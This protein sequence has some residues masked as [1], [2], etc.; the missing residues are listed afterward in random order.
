[1]PSAKPVV[2][3]DQ[4]RHLSLV[5]RESWPITAGVV[6][7]ACLLVGVGADPFKGLDSRWGDTLLRLRF[8]LGL[9]PR[10]DPNIFLIGLETN[11]LVGTGTIEGEYRIYA[12]I[13]DIL[14]DL[15]VSAVGMDLIMMRGSERDSRGVREAI[16]NN[17]H[18][19]LAE[20]QLPRTVA[21]SFPF[22]EREFPSG[23]I[24]I[25]SDTDGVH[26]RYWYGITGG[27][28]CEPSLAL[29][30]YLASFRPSRKVACPD[31]DNLVWK[32]LGADSLT[33]VER[34]IS[35]AG[36]L[37]NFRSPWKEPWDRGF[38]YL[39][40]HDLLAKYKAW[41]DA[42][43][44]PGQLPA[45]LPS[46]GNL[47]LIG[48]IA[49]GAGDAG[50]TPF[51][52][53][54]PFLQLQATALNDL[55]QRRSL[56][57]V[58]TTGTVGFTLV[59]LA[60]FALGGRWVRGM[61][62]LVLSCAMSV[63]V[64]VS[65]SFVLLVRADMMAPGI[66]PAAF[67][68]VA[69]LGEAGRRATLASMEK[70]QLRET[71]GRYFSPNVLKDVLKNPEAMQPREAELTVLLIDVRN[72]TTITELSG[73]K[74]MFDLLNEVFEIETQAVL[75]V[76]GSME[77]FVGDQFLAYW[78]APQ[79]QPDAA[80]R[81]LQAAA[82]IIRRLDALHETLEPALKELFGFGVAVHCGKA[83]F[84]NKGA[85][86]RLDYGILGDIVNGAARIESLT[87]YYGVREIATQEVMRKVSK[88]PPVRFLDRI[89]VKGK[90]QP[91]EIFDVL[92]EPTEQ[93]K[94]LMQAY[95]DAWRKYE[96]GDFAGAASIFDKLKECDPPSMVLAD[97]CR[98][99]IASPPSD[100]DGGYQFKEK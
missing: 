74:R 29:S 37:L 25:A 52:T 36:L 93:K 72:F 58:S 8:Q 46:R 99:M 66:T 3:L 77:H 6:L 44:D 11:D 100:W 9:G 30:T 67:V 38:K 10:P 62:G 79:E 31:M 28:T 63:L 78:G 90:T 59:G 80:D 32:E 19:V 96:R 91:I 84:G 71:L 51:G 98:E 20:M 43:A 26:R 64:I 24:D 48:S 55:L 81:A 56:T 35:G 27:F 34:K 53:S 92:V 97:R 17:G 4:N 41:H 16:R 69:L 39:S 45:G 68:A 1:M 5:V 47:V 33:M 95:E 76:D 57:E 40:A 23:L 15:E 2:E 83:L 61:P 73:T 22:A 50:S 75:A 88:K 89:R 94:A 65:L 7:L 54:E 21:R 12:G 42:G 14:T 82:N 87:K 70:A 60:L 18:V 85:R 13:L 86:M 49:P